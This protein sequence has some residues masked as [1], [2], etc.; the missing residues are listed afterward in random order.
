[1]QW[2][3]LLTKLRNEKNKGHLHDRSTRAGEV[4]GLQ[5]SAPLL[6]SLYVTVP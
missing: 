2:H 3:H 6:P 5:C 4:G 1:M